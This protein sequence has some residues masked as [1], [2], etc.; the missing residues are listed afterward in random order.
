MSYVENPKTRGS[1]IVCAIPQRGRCPNG[2]ADCF[3][4][5]G[6]SYLEPLGENTPNMP[7][8]GLAR[9][10][11]VRVNDGNDSANDRELVLRETRRYQDKFYNTASPDDLKGYYSAIWGYPL[12]VV[13]TV[14]PGAMTDESFY[15]WATDDVPKNLMFVRIRVNTWNLH[16][17][18]DPAVE[19]WTGLSVPVVLTFMA[20]HEGSDVQR[21]T[22]YEFRKRMLNS[23]WAITHAAWRRVMDRYATNPLVHSC[24]TEGVS[25]ACQHCGNCLREY[26]AT[27]ERIRA[28]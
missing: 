20:Y 23:Y 8:D 2:C 26:H 1:G 25:T 24:G 9:G 5:S 16:N 21:I 4:Q 7:P 18:V 15:P 28:R 11:V 12:P 6:R 22:D 10:R 17:V 19:R 13:L 14:N 27:M 3:F